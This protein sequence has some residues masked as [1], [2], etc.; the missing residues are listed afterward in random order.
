MSRYN[1]KPQI[2]SS[3]FVFPSHFLPIEHNALSS[4]R[5]IRL[6]TKTMHM[7]DGHQATKTKSRSQDPDEGDEEEWR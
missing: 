7:L 4:Y 5:Y 2:A 6:A 3:L 1:D